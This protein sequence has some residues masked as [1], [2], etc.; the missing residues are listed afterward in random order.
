M[1]T[2]Q[3][4]QRFFADNHTLLAGARSAAH[5]AKQLI[6]KVNPLM[7]TLTASVCPDC[8]SVCCINRHSRYDR[9]DVI[10]MTC[11]GHDV[12]EYPPY[13]AETAPC[14]F[15]NS[16][17]CRLERSLRPYRCTW[18]FCTPLLEHAIATTGPA[19]YRNFMGLFQQITEK[20]MIMINDFEQSHIKSPLQERALNKANN[21]LF[22]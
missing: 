4:I 11:L 5:E 7:E 20:R 16:T 2:V 9:S 12:P 18:Y 19:G 21:L 15:L 6:D 8:M 10:Y 3:D 1:H 14:R 13:L 22:Y 17:G